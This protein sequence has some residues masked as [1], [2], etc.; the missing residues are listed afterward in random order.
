[1]DELRRWFLEMD[2]TLDE[3]VRITTTTTNNL[4]YHMHSV[5]NSVAEFFFF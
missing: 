2:L 4:E 3:G 1:M 5:N